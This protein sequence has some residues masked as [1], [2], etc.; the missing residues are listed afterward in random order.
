MAVIELTRRIILSDFA[1]GRLTI[2]HLASGAVRLG[3]IGWRL[4]RDRLASLA[5]LLFGTLTSMIC[6]GAPIIVLT[7]CLV[8]A[9]SRLRLRRRLCLRNVEHDGRPG[10]L[11]RDLSRL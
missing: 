1:L 7:R 5:R 6:S 10:A 2:V 11:A 8:R 9:P 4:A 3:F